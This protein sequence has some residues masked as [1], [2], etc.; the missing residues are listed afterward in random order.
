VG[1]TAAVLATSVGAWLT[2][3][4]PV[5]GLVLPPQLVEFGV[6]LARVLLDV[7]L[8]AVLGLGLLPLLFSRRQEAELRPVLAVA[9]RGA[10]VA[11]LAWLSAALVSVV[12]Q[13]AELA[14]VAGVTATTLRDYVRN[15]SGAQA[16]LA[17]ACV[18]AAAAALAGIGIRASGQLPARLLVVT[19]G[20]GLLPLLATGHSGELSARWHDLTMV[21]LELH[22]FAATAWTGGLAAVAALLLT[23]P[24]LLARALPRFSGLAGLCLAVVGAT[25]VLNALV[26]LATTPGV[27][28]PAAL[29]SSQYGQLVLAKAGCLV[30]LA[31]LGG[32]IRFRLLPS[33]ARGHRTVLAGW[34]AG[35]LAV[36]GVA[37]GLAVVLSRSGVLP[38][39][40]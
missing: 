37:F 4:G 40:G 35:E 7:S 20:V 14:P 28:V 6:P 13:T 12:L 39:G 22:V 33:V 18:A 25:G 3:P 30:V 16:L 29:F 31:L 8:T 21:S 26:E 32:H 5:P 24:S 23:R 36:M 10:L 27:R 19:V 2:E 9:Y 17:T 38:A 1:L 34:V 15:F 11:A